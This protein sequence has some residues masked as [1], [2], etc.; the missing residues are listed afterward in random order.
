VYPIPHRDGVIQRTMYPTVPPK[1]AYSLTPV[2]ESLRRVVDAMDDR[3]QLHDEALKEKGAETCHG[4]DRT[5]AE[6]ASFS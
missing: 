2:G 5:E 6:G 3:E 1:G 4:R